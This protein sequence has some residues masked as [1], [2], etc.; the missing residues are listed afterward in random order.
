[1]ERVLR[2]KQNK[3]KH[4]VHVKIINLRWI[5]SFLFFLPLSQIL[6]SALSPVCGGQSP[7]CA[8][9]HLLLGAQR[10]CFTTLCP[11]QG[12]QIL[13]GGVTVLRTSDPRAEFSSCSP[14]PR[15][16]PEHPSSVFPL[17]GSLELH[18]TSP[19]RLEDA[20]GCLEGCFLAGKGLVPW[21]LFYHFPDKGPV[22][23]IP[24]F[25]SFPH[26][27]SPQQGLL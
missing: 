11:M 13:H 27:T 14:H 1:M 3:T 16:P 21:G 24:I 5:L 15:V 20:N 25:A 12:R 18:S 26:P 6:F 22:N 17:A 7:A 4:V 2:G 19:V 9:S 10:W 8:G 23:C